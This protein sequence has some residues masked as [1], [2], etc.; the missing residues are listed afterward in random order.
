M[1]RK[2][3]ADLTLDRRRLR[4]VNAT[5]VTGF[6]GLS[7]RPGQRIGIQPKT[8]RWGAAA[9]VVLVD[10]LALH[11]SEPMPWQDGA[12]Q[13]VSLRDP[14]GVPSQV[15]G[16]TRGATDDVIVL[17]GPPPFEIRDRLAHSEPT[18]LA[19]GVL[20]Q[21]VTDWTVQRMTPQDN[22]VQIDAV[23]YVP[24]VWNRAAPH[25]RAA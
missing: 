1:S 24:A 16:V 23:N 5:F 25:Q 14:T 12:L 21:E 3:H 19:F 15:V 2:Q 8:M 13:T 9:W 10:G 7:C 6:E 22:K 17:P 18:Q 4:R 11:V 20:G